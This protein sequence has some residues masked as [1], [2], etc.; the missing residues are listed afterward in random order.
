MLNI[1]I[2]CGGSGSRLW[3]LFGETLRKQFLNLT[4]TKYKMIQV[5]CIRALS[6]NYQTLFIICNVK[7]MFLS[8]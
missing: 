5:T 1:V 3:P 8:K 2:M 7:H 6:L 4:D